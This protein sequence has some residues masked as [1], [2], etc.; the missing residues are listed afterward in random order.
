MMKDPTAHF[1]AAG[2]GPF[3]ARIKR[4]LDEAGVGRRLHLAGLMHG[5]DLVDAY[6]AMNVFAFASLS[7]TQGVVLNEAMACGVVVVGL[8]AP[9]VREVVKDG[10]NGRLVRKEDQND[11][12]EAL[13]WCLKR[14]P[15]E[16]RRMKQSAL[17]TTAP[18]ALELCASRM[19]NV[20]EQTKRREFVPSAS[21]DNAWYALANRLKVEWDMFKNMMEAGGA[22][23]TEVPLRPKKPWPKIASGP[24]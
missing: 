21:R 12:S 17:E 9:G 6:H 13:S 4:I 18:F 10:I 15:E 2:K 14:P 19:L 23:M 7:E 3:V 16:K 24:F 20:Y 1:L 5:Q 22:A 8:D 11:F